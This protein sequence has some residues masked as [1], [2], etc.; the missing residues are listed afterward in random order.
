MTATSIDKSVSIWMN[1]Y[2][3]TIPRFGGYA[4]LLTWG[5]HEKT[6]DG[7]RPH[8]TINRMKVMAVIVAME[9]LKRPCNVVL[10][11]D[12][13]YVI[14]GC[15][16]WAREARQRGWRGSGG[17][18]FKNADLWERL[19]VLDAKHFVKYI[20][21]QRGSRESNLVDALARKRA[22]M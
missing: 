5:A 15:A 1:G 6:V 22:V 12:S 17:K 11:S 18:P 2:C 4:A 7:A 19:L 9:A 10:Y 16:N 21:Q 13:Q 3:D 8:T 14:N 20:W